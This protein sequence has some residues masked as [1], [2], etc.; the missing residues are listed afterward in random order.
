MTANHMKE[1]IAPPIG[2]A[3][4]ECL[5]SYEHANL[6][7]V[8]QVINKA[9]L[10]GFSLRHPKPFYADNGEIG[11]LPSEE[12]SRLKD[13]TAWLT[14]R[15]F[16]TV[17]INLRGKLFDVD[18]NL[19]FSYHHDNIVLVISVPEDMLWKFNEDGKGADIRRLVAFYKLCREI[20]EI[21]KPN[22]AAIDTE[23]VYPNEI[24]VEK[25]EKNGFTVFDP[26][27]FFSDDKINELFKW[28][29]DKYQ[30]RW[31]Q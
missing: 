22:Y 20:S 17:I 4:L 30:S 5:F 19:S 11:D 3:S 29:V 8:N 14:Q 24:T 21:K 7:F 31:D 27:I 12:F 28:Y 16:K 1:I 13:F 23:G 25:A 10:Q 26:T 9:F 2:G 18:T 15:Q 6:E